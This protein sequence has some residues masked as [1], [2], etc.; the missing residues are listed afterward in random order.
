VGRALEHLFTP[1]R[2]GAR[3][4][5]NRIAV[6]A[7]NMNWDHN[8]L[9]TREYINYC[10]RRAEGGAG[11][12]M[13]F[14]AASV[15]RAA[16]EIY[17]RVSLWD[18][19]NEGLLRELADKA[20]EHG[21]LLLS[22]VNHVGRRGTSATTE[23]PLMAPSEEPEPA[24]RE[25]PHQV[26]AREIADIVASFADAA[27][28]LH[29]CGWDGVEITSFGGQLIEQFW[30]PTVNRRTDDY[31]GSFSNRMRFG[32]E[33]IEA[34]RAAVPS[35][36]LVSFRMTGDP[37]GDDL[38][39]APE[40]MLAIGEHLDGLGL[41]DLFNVSGGTGA[42]L[43]T[44]AGTVPPDTFDR[45]CYLPLARAM[46]DRVSA[47]VLS[48]G[49]ILDVEQAEDA[50][51]KGDC[52]LVA[53]TRA[54]LADPDLPNLARKGEVERI[55]PCI[56]INDACIG[57]S[58][59]RMAVRCAVNPVAGHEALDRPPVAEKRQRV[60]VVGG[61][62]A[63]MEAARVAASRGHEVILLEQSDRLGGQIA[64]A[65][66]A[67]HRPHLGRHVDWLARELHH[68]KVDVQL[69]RPADPE[70]VA[71]LE[72][73]VVIVATGA[74][75][76]LPHGQERSGTAHLTDV[77]L[78]TGQRP[79]AAGSGVVVYDREGGIRGGSAAI[80][81]AEQGARVLLV[82]P[83]QSACQDLDPT[84]LPFIRRTLKQLDVDVMPDS[85]LV[86]ADEG[87]LV[88][89]DVWTRQEQHVPAQTA[90]FV[91]FH[92]ARSE[93][94][95]ALEETNPPFQVRGVGDCVAPR[96]LMDAVREG[97]LAGAAV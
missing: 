43:H 46:K 15:H 41:V 42:T 64:V 92:H 44:Q 93:L 54:T 32:V 4:T 53:M 40:D 50:L 95:L 76:R 47:P 90:I 28:R 45:G 34:V 78:L 75:S 5:K 88:V 16:G 19:R 36:F 72:P 83:L 91:G 79:I 29:R 33:V 37:L 48:A 3:Q 6:T 60:V 31:G 25:V 9:L 10:A 97:A 8:G 56:A 81:A 87:R 74:E 1:L 52:D 20:H 23:R 11:M 12:V 65:R 22:Q 66:R 57:R 26:T 35:D 51:A 58:Y 24:H 96:T 71:G 77:E 7:H 89:R 85:E 73:D 67:P 94:L 82:T 68:G 17:G 13:C 62:P 38:G 55:R 70:V 39:L 61:G 27:E 63:G 18:P 86:A 30:S 49:R 84:Q 14:G 2:L 59:K 80:A 69:R 21:A